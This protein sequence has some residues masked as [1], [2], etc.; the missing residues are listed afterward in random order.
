MRQLLSD[1]VLRNTEGTRKLE[2]NGISE[3]GAK[4]NV[5][6]PSRKECKVLI[7]GCGTSSFGEDMMYDGWHGGIV[8]V[9]W[10]HNAIQLMKEKYNARIADT[11][12]L[13]VSDNLMSFE[14]ADVTKSLPYSDSS[15]D[16]IICKG[17]LDAVLSSSGSIANCRALM[18]ECCRVLN[19]NHGA[20]VVVTSGAPDSRMLYFE[21]DWW[22]GGVETQ[23]VQKEFFVYVSKKA[24][25]DKAPSTALILGPKFSNEENHDVKDFG[26]VEEEVSRKQKCTT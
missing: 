3:I 9:D 4:L 8:N 18:D 1:Q 25:V 14:V 5:P 26:I 10:S 15:F 13:G 16:L 24:S 2:R 23:K 12:S 17:T 22:K 21:G 20:M 11:Q 7:I 19:N 6:F